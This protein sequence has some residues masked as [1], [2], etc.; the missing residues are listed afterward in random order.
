MSFICYKKKDYMQ[1]TWKDKT[2]NLFDC[3]FPGK[4]RSDEITNFKD[5]I[6]IM[7][8]LDLLI[9]VDTSSVHLAGAIG[10]PCIVLLDKGHDYRWGETEDNAWYD[11]VFFARQ[12][13]FLTWNSAIKIC[14]NKLNSMLNLRH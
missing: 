11:S 2:V 10:L 9:S 6:T 3:E 8:E 14:I 12:T 7:K 13:E 5:T 4:D 1:R